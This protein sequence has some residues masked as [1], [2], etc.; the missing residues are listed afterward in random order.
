MNNRYLFITLIII[1]LI[2]YHNLL[3]GYG[4]FSVYPF[5][6]FLKEEV[7]NEMLQ[8]DKILIYDSFIDKEYFCRIKLKNVP[9]KKIL[10]EYFSRKGTHLYKRYNLII[11]RKL[12]IVVYKDVNNKKLPDI[13]P[14][15]PGDILIINKTL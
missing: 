10:D 5:I 12:G 15:Y 14:L 11:I 9:I 7:Y 2:Y 1:V 13:D 6:P 4:A 8:D 3:W